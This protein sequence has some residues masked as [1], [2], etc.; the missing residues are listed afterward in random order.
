MIITKTNILA[1][2]RCSGKINYLL[3]TYLS[4]KTQGCRYVQISAA[5][6]PGTWTIIL[7]ILC[8]SLHDSQKLHC[9]ISYS[10]IHINNGF[11]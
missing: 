4:W 2:D 6:I 11:L 7:T 9:K 3:V 8:N 5:N 10:L 1:H